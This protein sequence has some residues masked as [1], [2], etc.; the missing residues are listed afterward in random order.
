MNKVED[1]SL[2]VYF[3]G[4]CPVCSREINF[5]RQR[6]GTAVTY[7]DV[8]ANICP[9]PDLSRDAALARFH[10]RLPDGQLLS[11]AAAFLALWAQT[12]GFGYVAKVLSARPFVAVLDVF[13]NL[14]L[15]LRRLWRPQ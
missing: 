4:A 2:V 12:P 9:A 14:F 6:T 7:C 8:S 1:N 5:Y 3:D 15:R 13:Y 10:V 11:G